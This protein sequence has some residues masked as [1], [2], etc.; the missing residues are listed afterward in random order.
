MAPA[1]EQVPVP[2]EGEPETATPHNTDTVNNFGNDG[3]VGYKSRVTVVGSGNWGS[4]AAKLIASNTLKL[5]SFHGMCPSLSFP[6][7]CFV[8]CNYRM[9]LIFQY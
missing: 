9:V 5:N 7:S 2:Q 3:Q 8:A 1:F 6:F 4:V